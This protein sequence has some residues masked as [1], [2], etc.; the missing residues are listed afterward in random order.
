[1]QIGFRT[2]I[3]ALALT[4]VLALPASAMSEMDI[5]DEGYYGDH[6]LDT[7]MPEVVK[8]GYNEIQFK[9][10]G[11]AVEGA[12]RDLICPDYEART[13]KKADCNSLVEIAALPLTGGTNDL[14]AISHLDGDCSENGCKAF[15]FK[16]MAGGVWVK[17]LAFTNTG[18]MAYKR[19]P[20]GTL[21][22]SVGLA[23]QKAVLRTW[24]YKDNGFTELE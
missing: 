9:S 2:M 14:I 22:T 10:Y 5:I 18:G 21:F 23:D 20:E 13:G 8:F 24:I 6:E 19:T 1:M 16:N 17:L 4:T 12:K 11:D 3:A 15:V 7:L